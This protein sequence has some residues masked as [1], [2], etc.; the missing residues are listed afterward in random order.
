MRRGRRPRGAPARFDS[1]LTL[2]VVLTG[3]PLPGAAQRPGSVVEVSSYRDDTA[4]RLHEAAMAERV[5]YD[6]GVVSYTA[7]VRQRM[8]A[9]LRM[10]LKDRTLYRAEATHRVWWNRDGEDLVQVLAFREQTPVG[11]NRDDLDLERFN[12]S[13]D[14]MN[15]RLFFGFAS[16]DDEMGVPDDDDFW[17]EHPLYPDWIDSYWFS[18]GDTLTLSLPD[19]RRVLAVELQVVPREADVHRMAGSL[20]IEPERGSLVRAV[21][22]LSDQFDAI[23]DI[24]DLRAEEEAGELSMIPGIV[25]PWTADISMISVDYALWDFEVWMPRTMRVDGVLGAGIF[26]APITMDYSYE[27][28]SVTTEA[29]LAEAPEDELPEVH[30]RTRSEA[31]AYLNELAFGRRVPHDVEL[32]R[33]SEEGEGTRYIYPRDQAFLGESPHLPPPVWKEAPGFASED[34]LREQFGGLADLPGVPA[35]QVPATLRWGLQRPDLIRYNRVEALSVGMRGQ[36]RPNSFVGPLSMTGTVRF[37]IGDLQPAVRADIARETL[38]RRITVSGYYE[39]ASIDEGARHLG[40]GNS[41]TA[42]FFGR[43]DGDYYRRYGGAIEWTPP[44][45]AR[46]TFRLRGHAEYQ[47]ATPVETQFAVFRFWNDAWAYRPNLLADEGWEYG[48]TLDVNPWW[49]TDPRLV[50]GGLDVM[51]QAA[52]GDFEYARSSLTGRLVFPLPADMRFAVEAGAGTSWG[53]PSVQRLWYVGGPRTLRGYP[54]RIAGGRSYGRA[55]AELARRYDFGAI[56]F[57]SDYGWA[58]ARNRIDLSDG[59]QSIGA[60]LSLL[61]GLIRIDGGWGLTAPRDFRLDFYLDAI[62]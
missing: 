13:F 16:D 55:R 62:L 46:R 7:V 51:V 37:G 18:T 10:P 20:W 23:R 41:L 11:V 43:D 27:F 1:I 33:R 5:R 34:D 24:P 17:F 6:D 32:S 39:L 44:T 58:G 26:K 50:Q 59:F 22:R 45:A 15:D 49:G 35:A 8:G 56:S 61:D 19:G 53:S 52:T 42:L 48:A 47:K 14:P 4:R 36:I 29:S 38:R 30:F 21:Y 60:G 40:L 3:L 54:S 25:K 28:E 12:G 2:L 9:S 57:F 31:M